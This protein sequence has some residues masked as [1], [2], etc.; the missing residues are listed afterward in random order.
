MTKQG[1]VLISIGEI[2]PSIRESLRAVLVAKKL[3]HTNPKT[4]EQF[5]VCKEPCPLEKLIDELARNSG[6]VIALSGVN[7]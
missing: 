6:Q 2:V 3:V 1:C 5:L 4:G 7:S